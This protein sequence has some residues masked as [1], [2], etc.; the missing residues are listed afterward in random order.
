MLHQNPA[1]AHVLALTHSSEIGERED[2]LKQKIKEYK[3]KI[4]LVKNLKL[5]YKKGTVCL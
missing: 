2:E 4:V 1:T 3:I 5:K